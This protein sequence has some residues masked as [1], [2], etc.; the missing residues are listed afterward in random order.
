MKATGM[1]EREWGIEFYFQATAHFCML[2]ERYSA[3]DWSGS[4]LKRDE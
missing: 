4:V 3:A 1:I 2:N